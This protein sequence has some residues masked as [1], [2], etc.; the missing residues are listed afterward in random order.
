MTRTPRAGDPDTHMGFVG[1][2][3]GGSAIRTVFPHWADALG[4]PTRALV[5]HDVPLNAP[6]S[7][8]RELVAAI[9]DDPQHWGALVTTHK[10]AVHAAAADLFDE[11]DEV[12]PTGRN[13]RGSARWCGSW[14]TSTTNAVAGALVT[15]PESGRRLPR[16]RRPRRVFGRR[17]S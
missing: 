10:V 17:V 15:V 14:C 13:R 16:V 2:S 5:G 7:S 8:Y 9:A 4:L 3:T 1:V 12:S 11:L 6:P